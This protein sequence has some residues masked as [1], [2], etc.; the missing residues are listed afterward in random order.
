MSLAS[1]NEQICTNEMMCFK[2]ESYL[3]VNTANT[4]WLSLRSLLSQNADA[5][6]YQLR[7]EFPVPWTPTFVATIKGY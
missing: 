1:E 6:C 3:P 7:P 4:L 2:E 5:W